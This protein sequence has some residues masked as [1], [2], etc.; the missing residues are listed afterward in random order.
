MDLSY[1]TLKNLL[2]NPNLSEVEIVRLLKSIHLNFTTKREDIGDY[3]KTED[4][5]SAYTMFYLPTN[6]LKLPFV[7]NQLNQK[8][9]EALKKT[10][11][12]DIGSGPGTYAL[13]FL[14]YFKNELSESL[15]LVDQSDS[16]LKQAS[17]IINH[18][19]PDFKK[20]HYQKNL[21]SFKSSG[22]ITL[23]FG[24]SLNE[25]G[26][27]KAMD[28]IEKL[29]PKFLFFIEPGTKD[30]FKTTLKIRNEM[31]K[32]GHSVIYPCPSLNDKCPLEGKDDWCHQILYTTHDPSIERL[33]QLLKKDRRSMPFISHFYNL[34]EEIV[35]NLPVRLIRILKET[36][37]ALMWEVCLEENGKIQTKHFEIPKKLLTKDV[38]KKF[39][40]S[41]VGVE[42]EFEIIK[43]VNDHLWRVKLL[44]QDKL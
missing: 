39:K 1:D 6:I 4:L 9:I 27:D 3:A 15:I 31:K 16:M 41:S 29:K 34:K 12:I 38:L 22:D 11:I 17:K 24:N 23:F 2:L 43:K 25:I 28:L 20:V 42:V 8:T 10:S 26:F 33:S 44:G 37:F 19:F 13:G 18:F 7:L 21:D 30:F 35:S 14:D 5:V 40:N 32:R 36:K